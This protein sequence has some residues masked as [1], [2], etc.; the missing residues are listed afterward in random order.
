[1]RIFQLAPGIDTFQHLQAIE[2][3]FPHPELISLTILVYSISTE[4][5]YNI[6]AIA[7]KCCDD[8][9]GMN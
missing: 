3:S 4:T 1:M 5:I 6:I 7:D 8:R 9:G 2:T